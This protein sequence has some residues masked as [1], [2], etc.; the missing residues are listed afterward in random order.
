M[1]DGVAQP[2]V[3]RYDQ[4]PR[5]TQRLV[6]LHAQDPLNVLNRLLHH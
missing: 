4:L 6:R 2:L 3:V 5:H 1:S